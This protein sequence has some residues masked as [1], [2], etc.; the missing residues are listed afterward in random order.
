MCVECGEG[1]WFSSVIR[2]Q[3]PSFPVVFVMGFLS[4]GHNVAAGVPAIMALH[5]ALAG[6]GRLKGKEG[7]VTRV[8]FSH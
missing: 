2:I 6:G 4:H 3:A 1:R 5:D 8:S 7:T